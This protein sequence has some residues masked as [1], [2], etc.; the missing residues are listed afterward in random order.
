MLRITTSADQYNVMPAILADAS[1][2]LVN[3]FPRCVAVVLL[4]DNPDSGWM[5]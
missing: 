4:A 1:I 2:S 3:S 5:K